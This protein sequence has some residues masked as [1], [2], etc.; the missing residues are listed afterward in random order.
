MSRFTYIAKKSLFNLMEIAVSSKFRENL[1]NY[2]LLRK[3]ASQ[4]KI[5]ISLQPNV[6]NLRYSASSN[7]LSH[8]ISK[9]YTIS[10][11]G[12]RD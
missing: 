4:T 1:R 2:F 9:V 3:S 8:G 7:N 10:L 5:S 11:Q 12:Y 6:V